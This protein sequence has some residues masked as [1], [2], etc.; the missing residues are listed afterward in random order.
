MKDVFG[1]GWWAPVAAV[2]AVCNAWIGAW[3]ISSD[4]NPGSI[5]G[6]SLFILGG[7]ALLAGLVVRPRT[8]PSARA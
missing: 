3:I 2:L 1:Q 8:R 5:V 7:V 6:G 4:Q